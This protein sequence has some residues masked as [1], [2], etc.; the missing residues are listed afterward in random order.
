M[1]NDLPFKEMKKHCLIIRTTDKE[2]PPDLLENL[3][4]KLSTQEE[5]E[6]FLLLLLKAKEMI[7]ANGGE[8]RFSDEFMADQELFQNS[9]LLLQQFINKNYSYKSN[10]KVHFVVLQ[11]EFERFLHEVEY[12]R[13][14][15]NTVISPVFLIEDLQKAEIDGKKL[16]IKRYKKINYIIVGLERK[17]TEENKQ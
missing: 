9:F 5:K 12:P 17:K 10:G 15:I 14:L 3:E 13:D 4:E 7:D 6:Q 2:L 16:Q 1:F 8:L 11:R